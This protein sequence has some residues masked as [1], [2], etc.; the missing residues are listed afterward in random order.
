MRARVFLITL[1]SLISLF[2]S[3]QSGSVKDFNWSE[4]VEQF[5]LTADEEKLAKIYLLKKTV[6][7]YVFEDNNFIMY[8]LNQY[9]IKVNSDDAIESSNKIYVPL[10]NT[11]DVVNIKARTILQN[12][13][14]IELDKNNIKEIPN[15]ENSNGYKVFAIEGVEKGSVIEYFYIRKQYPLLY[16]SD[17][18]QFTSPVKESFF[19][20][21]TPDH[22]AFKFKGYNGY[23]AVSDTT[24]DGRTIYTA[25][26]TNIPELKDEPFSNYQANKMKVE[27]KL[28]YNKGKSNKEIYTWADFAQSQFDVTNKLTSKESGAVKKLFKKIEM[29]ENDNLETKV[30]KIENYVKSNIVIQDVYQDDYSS[31]DHIVKN[32]FANKNGI[33]KLYTSLFTEA[34]INYQ[35]VITSERNETR[36]DGAFESWRFLNN[37]LIYFPDLKSFISPEEPYLRYPLVPFNVTFTEGLFLKPVSVGELQTYVPVVKAIP[38]LPYNLSAHITK[39][40]VSFNS[41]LDLAHINITCEFTGYYASFFQPYYQMIPE[42]KRKEYLESIVKD[43]TKD[44]KFT[45]LTV[46]NTDINIPTSEKPFTVKAQLDGASL[47]ELAGNKILFKVGELIGPQMELYQDKERKLPVENDFN[48]EYKRSIKIKIPEGYTVKNLNDI[49]IN[50][51]YEKGGDKIFCFLSDY[52]LGADNVLDINVHEYYKEISCPIEQFEA[53]RK[54]INAAADFNKVTLV[55]EPK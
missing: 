28:A 8:S 33:T 18:V 36:F 35:L 37:Y 32:K 22:L 43:Y 1:L 53:Y 40:E 45:S 47:I 26:I 17:W 4:K 10:S 52:K 15:D 49:N 6:L 41:G 25:H 14:T 39:A 16:G 50:H 19:Q 55:I 54:V 9:V 5:S 34:G 42:E 51:F 31:L 13:K 27:Y 23:P 48:R 29:N 20:L 24:F 12:G 7:E 30:K 46:E 21:S 44:T 3:A 38:A 2:V 11:I